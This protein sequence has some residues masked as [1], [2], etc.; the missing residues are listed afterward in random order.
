MSQY[1]L[2]GKFTTKPVDRNKLYS[3]LKESAEKLETNVE[4]CIFYKVYLDKNDTEAIWI[5]E[6]WE[7]KKFH[8]DSLKLQSVLNVIKEAKPLITGMSHIELE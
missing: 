2:F 3:I 6:L 8:D 1:P 7:D 5:F 4:G